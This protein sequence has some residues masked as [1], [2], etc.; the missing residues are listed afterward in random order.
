MFPV[1]P[2]YF[3]HTDHPPLN[4]FKAQLSSIFPDESP[5]A[6][7]EVDSAKF[8]GFPPMPS[9]SGTDGLETDIQGSALNTS[10]FA[11]DGY[12]ADDVMSL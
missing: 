10:L 11:G 5:T 9:K 7:Q 2:I 1:C 12:D 8:L 4:P 3:L 6:S